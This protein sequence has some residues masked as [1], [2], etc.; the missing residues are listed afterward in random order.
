MVLWD[1]I[2]PTAAW[3]DAQVGFPFRRVWRLRRRRLFQIPSIIH[4]YALSVLKFPSPVEKEITEKEQ[5]YWD[6]VVDKE[7]VAEV[8]FWTQIA[9]L[10]GIML[11]MIRCICML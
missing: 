6:E 5:A 3:I 1:Q 2:E 4:E 7:T 10:L 11:C 8:K 9:D